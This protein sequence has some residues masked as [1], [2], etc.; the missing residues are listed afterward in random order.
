MK[1]IYY[2]KYIEN[3]KNIDFKKY[4]LVIKNKNYKQYIVELDRKKALK[5][6]IPIVFGLICI[7]GLGLGL[8]LSKKSSGPITFIALKQ[9]KN[10][11]QN[12]IN[13]YFTH[14]YSLKLLWTY[15]N[16]AI[17]S[18]I[19]S[20]KE[21]SIAQDASNKEKWT[22]VINLKNSKNRYDK[23][24]ITIHLN[25]PKIGTYERDVWKQITSEISKLGYQN[26]SDSNSIGIRDVYKFIYTS[27]SKDIPT[28]YETTN[29]NIITFT[30]G[31]VKINSDGAF[32][33]TLK[34]STTT[35]GNKDVFL[36]L[37]WKVKDDMKSDDIVSAIQTAGYVN[38]PVYI[39]SMVKK[40]VNDYL[41]KNTWGI[42]PKELT[43]HSIDHH[44]FH[45]V[46]TKVIR[47]KDFIWIVTIDKKSSL[48]T[49]NLDFKP[50]V[51]ALDWKDQKDAIN[52]LIEIAEQIK[53]MHYTKELNANDVHT[54]F[55]DFLESGKWD[56]TPY[57]DGQ[58]HNAATRQVQPII[59]TYTN[60]KGV[61]PSSK[62]GSLWIV[63]IT[64]TYTVYE[65]EDKY[66]N[67]FWRTFI[68]QNIIELGWSWQFTAPDP[69]EIAKNVVA[70]LNT[71]PTEYKFKF[72]PSH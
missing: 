58:S 12:E 25:L 23:K 6:V 61:I 9:T 51:I 56:F 19:M 3:L 18:W 47:N 32:T 64:F 1:K 68:Y 7:I 30:A 21:G 59:D 26:K 49:K 27:I 53:N 65:G 24:N 72:T 70:K 35:D 43:N 69:A 38:A 57:H 55:K 14:N 66:Y 4:L 63:T 60:G 2:K 41:V 67:P 28:W 62:R 8:G 20:Y 15:K 31:D 50:F 44:T 39:G 16:D 17:T 37:E 42:K 36:T 34:A 13:S 46:A 33:T 52:K 71:R 5:I 11:V 22:V 45:L 29:N 54:I 40:S 48:K 10:T